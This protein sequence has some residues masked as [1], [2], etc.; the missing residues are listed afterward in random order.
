RLAGGCVWCPRS[1]LGCTHRGLGQRPLEH[2]P[3]PQRVERHLELRIVLGIVGRRRLRGGR[4][5]RGRRDRAPLLA[6]EMPGK[7][8]L[9]W[10]VAA[11]FACALSTSAF[12]PLRPLV[13]TITPPSRNRS[14]TFTA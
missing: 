12:L 7:V 5:E 4:L 14:A 13:V 11:R 2:C 9:A 1:G 6:L 3:C 10:R 8:L